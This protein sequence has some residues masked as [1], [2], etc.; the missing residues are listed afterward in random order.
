M[1][2]YQQNEHYPRTF[3]LTA[4]SDHLTGAPLASPTVLISKAGGAFAAAAGRVTEIGFGLYSIALTPA[5]T[6]TLGNL[7]FRITAA[8]CDPTDF[9]DVIVP[10]GTELQGLAQST[11]TAFTFLLVQSADHL[12]GALGATPTVRL[13]KAGGT[14][15]AAS[16]AVTELGGGQYKIVLSQADVDTIGDLALHI[17]A[18]GCDPTDS[19]EQVVGPRPT[20]APTRSTLSFYDRRAGQIVEE[21][22]LLCQGLDQD[23]PADG[24]AI[25]QGLARMNDILR[26]WYTHA[27]HQWRK[28]EIVL[29]LNPSQTMY[30]LG[31]AATDAYWADEEDFYSTTTSAAAVAGA[32]SIGLT[33]ATDY[34]NGDYV[35]IELA[36]GTRQWTTAVKSGSTLTLDAVLTDNVNAAASVY[37]FTSRP[38]RPLQVLHARRRSSSDSVDIPVKVEAHNYYRDQP[39]KLVTGTPVHVFYQPTLTSGRLYIWQA[40]SNA[41]QQIRLTV[42]R[43]FTV[44][45][46]TTDVIDIPDEWIEALTYTLAVRLEP[47]Y[48]HL[49]TARLQM[50]RADAGRLEADA[51]A[52]DEDSG[53]IYFAPRRR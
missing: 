8:G 40:P 9:R 4:S 28:Q 2:T 45:V 16:G 34:A 43:P 35:G 25:T 24:R 17:T 47:T 23:E 52:F 42:A 19:I 41:T 18:T 7:S 1:A 29:P 50:L 21:A 49:D 51:L 36:D 6:D 39:A 15:A 53:S 20:S 37:M 38:P 48:G 32:T 33:D 14:L 30:L 44:V 27:A 5:D 31:D 11:Q 46:S 12:T 10:F 26:S 3:V 22:L 13:S